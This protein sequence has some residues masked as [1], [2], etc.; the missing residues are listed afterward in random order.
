VFGSPLLLPSATATN[1]FSQERTELHGRLNRSVLTTQKLPTPQSLLYTLLL[2]LDLSCESGSLIISR[3]HSEMISTGCQSRRKSS[4]DSAHL[5]TSTSDR[6]AI[7]PRDLYASYT[8]AICHHLRS[9]ARGD[10]HVLATRTRSFSPHSF[11]TCAPKF[12]SSLP[13]ALLE[14]LDM[15]LIL[16][17][18][19]S[20]LDTYPFALAYGRALVT[21][22]G[23][24]KSPRAIDVRYE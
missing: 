13:P 23:C 6:S 10:L 17:K 21:A 12:S 18:L 5:S 24:S 1:R 2:V 14:V 16:N 11:A 9:A 8:S 19:C 7:H 3:Q 4:A 15:T 22:I 20:R